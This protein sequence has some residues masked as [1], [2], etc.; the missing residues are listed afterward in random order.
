MAT[1][2][3]KDPI[4]VGNR[5]EE[6]GLDRTKLFHAREAMV[7]ARADCTQNDPPGAPGW[8]A[9]RMG[10]RRLREV[11]LT[12]P[13]WEKDEGDQISAIVNKKLGVRLAV[14]NTDDATGL[15][16]N[17]RLP[18]NRSKKGAATDRVVQA[19]QGSFM[20]ALDASLKVVPLKTRTKP[21]GPIITWY[22]CVYNDG[23]VVRSELSCPSSLD[24]GFFTDFVERIFLDDM[25]EGGGG[26]VRRRDSGDGG[27]EFNIPVTR[28][29]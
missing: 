25:D 5:L 18:Q 2:V 23:D 8:S 27:P 6:L 11:M 10:T 22:I 24:N 16:I 4:E 13:D 17:G 21:S 3:L 1:K 14:A 20:D 26:A 9:W 12:E 28:K 7:S 19:N 29:K 15:D